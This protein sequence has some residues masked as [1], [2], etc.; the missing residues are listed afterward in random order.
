V[1]GDWLRV[2]GTPAVHP[3]RYGS[4][5]T[6]RA[7]HRMASDLKRLGGVVAVGA[8]LAAAGCGG[9][10]GG[11]GGH[12]A[13]A[14]DPSATAASTRAPS[15]SAREALAGRVIVVD[16]GHNDGNFDHTQQIDRLVNAGGFRKACDTTGT[17]TDAGYHE[18]AFTFDVTKRLTT[19]LRADGAKVVLTRTDDHSVGPC[20]DERAD[21]GNRAHADA[22]L[23][24]HADGGPTDGHG[25]HVMY[26]PSMAGGKKVAA[27]SHRLAAAV[28]DAYRSGTG[29]PTANYIGTDGLNR[30]T[31]MAGLNLSTVPKVLVECGNM[32]NSGDAGKLSSANFRQRVAVAL[33][34]AIRHYLS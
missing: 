17:E 24:I 25:F 9:G 27:A 10:S 3:V 26:P 2:A 19:L 16:A 1:A 7:V 20:V 34:A 32:R 21:I 28:R 11:G 6:V 13:A 5:V 22:A 14:P 31:D 29:L 30:R 18:A 23:S 8:V 33:D 15:P 12:A 4:P